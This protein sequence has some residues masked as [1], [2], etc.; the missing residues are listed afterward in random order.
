MTKARDLANA[1][2]ALSAV[3]ATELGYLDGVTSALQTQIDGKV[4]TTGGSVVTVAS[5]TTVPLTIQNNGTGNSFVINDVVSDTTPLV[6]DADGNTGI[7]TSSPLADLHIGSSTTVSDFRMSNSAAST[8]LSMYTSSNDVVIYN[9]TATGILQLGTN[10]STDLTIDASGNTTI[11]SIA[12]AT[13]STAAVGGGY[14]G[15]PQVQVTSGGRTLVASDAGKHLY[16]TTTSGQTVTI[17]ANSSVA[18]PVGTTI[19]I[20][21][22]NGISTSIAITTDALRLAGT[23][24]TG[25]RTLASNGVCTLIKIASTEWISSGNGLS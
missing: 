18:F 4:S 15:L 13:T 19:T 11:N 3:S 20:V 25:T 21:N 8:V 17:P 7:G 16:M 14:M 5:G 12:D 10:N 6:V 2:T 22:A 9:A 1:S 24:S 23:T